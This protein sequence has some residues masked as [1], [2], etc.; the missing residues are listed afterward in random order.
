M[1]TILT[2]AASILAFTIGAMAVFSG[3]KVLLG[4]M[5]D[6]YVIDWVPV[7]NF[8]VGL[9]TVAFTAITLWRNGKLALPTA[10]ATL[11]SHSIVMIVLQTIYRDVVAPE[12][13]KAMTVR[14]TA[15][16]IILTLLLIQVWMN[17]DTRANKIQAQGLSGR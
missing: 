15:W 13:T 3:G 5:P 8:S 16:T 1:N 4:Q 12:S 6:Y 17:R 10:I 14:I 2:K 11:S 7:Y 9:I